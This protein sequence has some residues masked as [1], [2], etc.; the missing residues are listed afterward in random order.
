[1]L[2]RLTSSRTTASTPSR[3]PAPCRPR[4]L[5]VALSRSCWLDCALPAESY[6]G[7]RSLHG[8][9][10]AFVHEGHRLRSR[11]V[12]GREPINAEAA[13]LDHASDGSIEVAATADGAPSR[14]QSILPVAH[15]FVG[16]QSVLDERQ[17]T[18]SSQHA[19]H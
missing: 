14:R 19:T 2:S 7:T 6:T 5:S 9:G 1:M 11:H 12:T 13:C 3:R 17:A 8:M 15:A 10:A 4:S 18:A 16:R